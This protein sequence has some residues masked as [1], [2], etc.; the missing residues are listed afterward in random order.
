MDTLKVL[1]AQSRTEACWKTFKERTL[2]KKN[3]RENLLLNS[4]FNCLLHSLLYE[5][6]ERVW[7]IALEFVLN[8]V[9]GK[10]ISSTAF[11]T[12]LQQK[13]PQST[14]SKIDSIPIL[15]RAAV[16]CLNLEEETEIDFC[17]QLATSD[18]RIIPF[19]T[20]K[21]INCKDFS[22]APNF[23]E[24]LLGNPKLCFGI[25]DF[26]NLH[27]KSSRCRILAF[28]ATTIV[29]EESLE[30]L[31]SFLIWN[32]S[33]I[34][35]LELSN[36]TLLIEYFANNPNDSDN[37]FDLFEV[38]VET[39][40]NGLMKFGLFSDNIEQIC[41]KAD[42]WIN[43]SIAFRLGS[44]LLL[45]SNPNSSL[46][47]NIL[48]V[49]RKFQTLNDFAK[50]IC[51][52]LM[53]KLII[54]SDEELISCIKAV[55]A[56]SPCEASTTIE[57]I[58]ESFNDFGAIV[59]LGCKGL[60]PS[61]PIYE[62][63]FDLI[64]L[65]NNL[66][67]LSSI[68]ISRLVQEG[69]FETIFGLF[70]FKWTCSDCDFDDI[71]KGFLQLLGDIDRENSEGKV[72]R[73]SWVVDFFETNFD[74]ELYLKLLPLICDNVSNSDNI[75]FAFVQQKLSL[76]LSQKESVTIQRPCMLSL[77]S[78]FES[79]Q[80]RQSRLNFLTTSALSFLQGIIQKNILSIDSSAVFICFK[81]LSNLSEIAVVDPRD[82]WSK[83][84]TL[85]LQIPE[86][87]SDSYVTG[88]ISCFS[89]S[90]SVI[91]DGNIYLYVVWA[92]D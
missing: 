51:S 32:S 23:I 54:N 78:L 75:L 36:I 84:V 49:I 77:L 59:R 64:A 8:C 71:S 80:S 7:K 39:L 21:I 19:I 25:S 60:R 42:H 50:V 90:L 9:K 47:K 2:T 45:I 48:K 63:Y 76:Y 20:E 27:Y 92:I 74:D 29:N 24:Y 69:H 10:M 79:S 43:E 44:L 26:N 41:L 73:Y 83:Y 35:S 31:S 18:L 91:P 65:S 53:P 66:N 3:A 40:C 4:D 28:L 37:Y 67:S 6:N 52:N 38:Y 15:E 33:R 56:S 16:I 68:S 14:S 81:L 61:A 72:L 22:L 62:K 55:F 17:L 13:L 89:S 1:E 70:A 86:L 46:L 30:L 11:L 87:T 58:S 82:I 5:N 88:A 12:L 57:I 34:C 85:L